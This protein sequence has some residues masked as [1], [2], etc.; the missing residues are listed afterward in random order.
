MLHD[1][2][3]EIVF[4]CLLAQFGEELGFPYKEKTRCISGKHDAQCLKMFLILIVVFFP[5]SCPKTVTTFLPRVS[6]LFLALLG[7]HT[8]KN[9]VSTHME[10]SGILSASSVC[11][12]WLHREVR[13]KM[14]SLS[15]PAH[16][17]AHGER[18]SPLLLNHKT[19]HL[20]GGVTAK[21]KVLHRADSWFFLNR[22]QAIPF[23]PW[24]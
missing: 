13:K 15:P 1:R 24:V 6:L 18:D 3:T 7:L 14:S 22:S 5:R 8:W 16:S 12:K 21:P 9:S 11:R 2:V 4:V 17:H 19:T 10:N 20:I 23:M